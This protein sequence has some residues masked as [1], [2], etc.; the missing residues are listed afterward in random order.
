[1]VF[2]TICP[3]CQKR[4]VYYQRNFLVRCDDCSKNFFAFKLHEEAVPSRIVFAA[5]NNSQ[6][7]SERFSFQNHNVPNQQVQYNMLHILERNMDSEP[8]MNAT[9]SDEHI[10]WDGRSGGN[11]EGSCSGARSD[12]SEVLQFSAMN[13][14][15]SAEPFV[16]KGTTGSLMSDPPDPN[17]VV[18]QNLSREDASTV[19]NAAGSDILERLG[20]RNKEDGANNSH[21]R[22]S[23]KHKRKHDSLSDANSSD[24]KMFNENVAAADDQ[25]AEHLPSTVDRQGDATETPEENQ[26]S[27]WKETTNVANQTSCRPMSAHEGQE[28]FDFDNISLNP[29]SKKRQRYNDL[30]SNADM[31]GKQIFDDII[32]G[33][34]GQSAPPHVPNKV[35]IQ[36]KAKTRDKCD[37][38]NIRAEAID[39]V[40]EKNIDLNAAFSSV[41]P[42]SY[43]S[44]GKKMSSV[45][46][47]K[48]RTGSTSSKMGPGTERLAQ[49]KNHSEARF[50]VKSHNDISSEQNRSSQ[51]NVR[52]TN[53]ISS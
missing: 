43:I 23:C 52:G 21:S 18:T 30:P 2:W 26:Q 17:F 49:N 8:M 46:V 15:H 38:G 13:Q 27:S 7:L 10:R 28:I 16:D 44:S 45:I 33:A 29:D 53:E 40:G 9:R 24:D 3:H 39:T 6:A 32:T 36:E 51:E 22:D 50:S 4:F 1:M 35:D 31:S 14:T 37:Q 5:P 47:N 25:S 34:D 12:S 11:Q 20:E 42:D 41:T 19:L 48:L